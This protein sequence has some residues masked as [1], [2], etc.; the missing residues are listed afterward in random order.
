MSSCYVVVVTGEVLNDHTGDLILQQLRKGFTSWDEERSGL[1]INNELQNFAAHADTGE[2]RENGERVVLH[3]SDGLKME[4]VIN[5]CVN[6]TKDAIR[7]CLIS[8]AA[9]K[10]INYAGPLFQGSGAWILADGVFGFADL[11]HLFAGNDVRKAADARPNT[12]LHI[13][14]VPEG[15]WVSRSVT[16]SELDVSFNVFINEDHVK[17]SNQIGI[18]DFTS[19]IGYFIEAEPLEDVMETTVITGNIR[20]SRPT[21]YVFPAG[22]GD[23]AL[24]GVSGFNMLVNGGY[25]RRPC[26][27]EFCKH[28]ERIDVVLQTHAGSDNLHGLSSVLQR[29]VTEDI[30]PNIGHVYANMGEITTAT[31]TCY[32]ELIVSLTCELNNVADRWEMLG[33]VP[34][35]C[36]GS[37][38]QQPINLY[39][40][41]GYGTLDMYVL[42]PVK[43][44][45]EI[46]DFMQQWQ[47]NVKTFK[48]I[49]NIP[50]L[51][52]VSICALLVW[53]PAAEEDDIIKIL[54]TGNAPQ[55]KVLGGLDRL[56]D[57]RCLQYSQCSSE[58]LKSK[59]KLQAKPE[60]K[61]SPVKQPASTIRSAGAAKSVTST[62]PNIKHNDTANTTKPSLRTSVIQTPVDNIRKMPKTNDT[63]SE[64]KSKNDAKLPEPPVVHSTPK[65]TVSAPQDLALSAA[66]D[67]VAGEEQSSS[68]DEISS[69]DFTKPPGVLHQHTEVTDTCPASFED[70]QLVEDE[71]HLPALLLTGSEG[72]NTPML[73]QE[74][75]TPEVNIDAFDDSQ[76]PTTDKECGLDSDSELSYRSMVI[77]GNKTCEVTQSTILSDQSH[78]G[79]IEEDVAI[80]GILQ[81]EIVSSSPELPQQTMYE[82]HGITEAAEGEAKHMHLY[83]QLNSDMVSDIK[84]SSG[85]T[86]LVVDLDAIPCHSSDMSATG[87]VCVGS[88]SQGTDQPH[89]K[90]LTATGITEIHAEHE[91][92]D[93]Q[94]MA[95]NNNM[96]GNIGNAVSS[97]IASSHEEVTTTTGIVPT[98][99]DSESILES[100]LK[101]DECSPE[102]GGNAG[103]VKCNEATVTESPISTDCHEIHESPLERARKEVES[104]GISMEEPLVFPPDSQCSHE[105]LSPI[106]EEQELINS[107]MMDSAAKDVTID[108][109]ISPHVETP[110]ANLQPLASI[111]NIAGESTWPEDK[112]PTTSPIDT[113]DA[114]IDCQAVMEQDSH[115]PSTSD[116]NIPGSISTKDPV[117]DRYTGELIAQSEEPIEGLQ[118]TE[119]SDISEMKEK[120]FTP[121]LGDASHSVEQVAADFAIGI[122]DSSTNRNAE[123]QGM[124]LTPDL[125]DGPEQID[126]ITDVSKDAAGSDVALLNNSLKAPLNELDAQQH[127]DNSSINAASSNTASE[128]D[129]RL[130]AMDDQPSH[131]ELFDNVILGADDTSVFQSHPTHTLAQAA[132]PDYEMRE[133]TSPSNVMEAQPTLNPNADTFVPPCRSTPTDIQTCN[134]QESSPMLQ[135][136]LNPEADPFLLPMFDSTNS[137]FD[138]HAS[139]N[140]FASAFI[141]TQSPPTS[142]TQEY[143]PRSSQSQIPENIESTELGALDDPTSDWEPMGLPTPPPTTTTKT[144]SR[145]PN[146]KNTEQKTG[147]RASSSATKAKTQVKL[148]ER[149]VEAGHKTNVTADRKRSGV[150]KPEAR[151]PQTAEQSKLAVKPGLKATASVDSTRAQ[152]RQ[153][154]SK[155]ITTLKKEQVPK[156]LAAKRPIGQAIATTPLKTKP[157]SAV[158]P[159]YLNLAYIPAH[160]KQRYVDIGFFK[161]VRARYYV[162][163]TRNPSLHIFNTLLEAKNTWDD[164]GMLTTVI[165]T[166]DDNDELVHWVALHKE[167][168]AQLNIE[169][170]PAA[171]RCS[172]NLQDHESCCA[173]YRLEF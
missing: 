140:P 60:L 117:G 18:E 80:E 118:S 142:D 66:D 38:P 143:K 134:E 62:N 56:K 11:V 64:P 167:E 26:F 121:I 32:S 41:V 43:D 47:K 69:I 101:L 155:P 52:F 148:T 128:T 103:N 96:G 132:L 25:S 109:C 63:S 94:V 169:I 92:I 73:Q 129:H 46:K 3:E 35:P 172:V 151:I 84:R 65:S 17:L 2:A 48:S 12:E 154:A 31:S 144:T 5:G 122:T 28:L 39:H 49:E 51:D 152:V 45:T 161:T 53:Y 91:V 23:S 157:V 59:S 166:Y 1:D 106:E 168:L 82:S 149:S 125:L 102:A 141:P 170:A 27:W 150:S 139:L 95:K 7:T 20:F 44:S 6:T 19:H 164:K 147:L 9:Y 116:D 81:S 100:Q 57:L 119:F 22:V 105:L 135:Q 162:Y 123:K 93:T 21:I 76:F 71:D 156:A 120:E 75:A 104:A 68:E 24:F 165:P 89:E 124:S 115:H 126:D 10:Y 112:L 146:T 8:G 173:A 114:N 33:L 42:N 40:K 54:F 160:G 58:S 110:I 130:A 163:S 131:S 111:S 107:G 86:N 29:K 36:F 13:R 4:V 67:I 133:Y 50:L 70:Q 37:F 145:Q 138:P 55:S 78:T 85:E 30:C 137:A 113:G 90:S 108:E 171:F 87:D 61:I 153:T 79:V 83:Q 97:E 159:V 136:R 99:E 74:L 98:E 88:N 72:N 16:K 34:T 158:V 15:D 77:D 127:S 14:S